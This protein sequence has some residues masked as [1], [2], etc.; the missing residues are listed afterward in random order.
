[1]NF[2]CFHQD[3]IEKLKEKHVPRLAGTEGEIGIDGL[4]CMYRTV[5]RKYKA[6]DGTSNEDRNL[7]GME[8]RQGEAW[9]SF[10]KCEG[11]FISF[12]LFSPANGYP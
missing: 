8:L 12:K 11:V 5:R 10:G 3:C 9:P 2:G 1:M 4:W 6:W 7:S